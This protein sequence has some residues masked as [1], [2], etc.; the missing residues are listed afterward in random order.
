MMTT[1]IRPY[2]LLTVESLRALLK[3]DGD[4]VDATLL[5]SLLAEESIADNVREGLRRSVITKMDLRDQ[6]ILDQYQDEI[7]R[8][9]LNSR[10]LIP[11]SGACGRGDGFL[12]HPTGLYG[13]TGETRDKIVLRLRRFQSARYK[14][15]HTLGSGN[16]VG[17]S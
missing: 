10:L 8:L 4:E 11:N 3:R 15:G 6:P 1:A 7:F 2:G 5:D 9:P 14:L 12:T 13:G 17:G 16:G